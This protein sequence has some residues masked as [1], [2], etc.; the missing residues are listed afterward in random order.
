MQRAACLMFCRTRIRNKRRHKKDRD[1]GGGEPPKK[2]TRVQPDVL[3]DL[4]LLDDE[5]NERNIA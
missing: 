3:L 4:Q 2:R 5:T 1:A